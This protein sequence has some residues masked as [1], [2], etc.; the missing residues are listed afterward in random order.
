[1]KLI[2]HELMSPRKFGDLLVKKLKC[3]RTVLSAYFL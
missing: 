2:A 3:K 1:M